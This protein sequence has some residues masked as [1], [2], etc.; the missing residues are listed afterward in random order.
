LDG[1][2]ALEAAG[3][4]GFTEPVIHLSVPR[5][6]HAVRNPLV[7]IH[8][9]RG[10]TSDQ[11]I[12]A[13]L[14]RVRPDI[15]AV[16]GAV[17]ARSDRAAATILAMVVQQR[18]TCAADLS[19][20]A[21]GL[22]RNRRRSLVI[23][24]ATDIAD[25]ARSLGELDFADLCRRFGLPSPERQALRRRLAG[26]AYL[27]ARWTRYCVVAEI[28]GAQHFD[29]ENSV[30]DLL[31]HNDIA[32]AGDIVLR[33]PLLGLRAAPAEFMA[34]VA[35]GLELGGWPGQVRLGRDLDAA[36]TASGAARSCYP[37]DGSK[38]RT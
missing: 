28:D 16:R 33:I 17:W 2:T 7:T 36:S 10:L 14:R 27:D 23:R 15:A 9:L 12:D 18:L 38:Y 1:V 25:G 30:P 34:Q 19:S 4:I 24:L 8:H 13:E 3:L 32:L 20:A 21:Q 5:G 31:R 29:V 22:P 6:G 26:T 35:R 37:G 11:V